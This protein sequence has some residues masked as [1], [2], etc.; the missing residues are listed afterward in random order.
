MNKT[1]YARRAVYLWLYGRRVETPKTY[2]SPDEL[3]FLADEPYLAA[4]LAFGLEMGHL[5]KTR[6][7]WR[8]TAAGMLYT[9]TTFN[10]ERKD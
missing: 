4:A 3:G 5:D 9:E 6:G 10:D 7:H 2:F 1:L 8:M